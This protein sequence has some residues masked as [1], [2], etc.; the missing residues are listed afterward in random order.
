MRAG[1][2]GNWQDALE[3]FNARRYTNRLGIDEVRADEPGEVRSALASI[4]AITVAWYGVR[5]FC[6]HWGTGDPPPDFAS[7]VDDEEEAGRRDPYRWVAA[8]T[9]TIAKTADPCT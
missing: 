2:S 7:H 6:D 8:L 5:L 1:M 4:G 3:G 9:H